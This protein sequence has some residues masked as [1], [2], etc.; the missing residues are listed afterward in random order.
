MSLRFMSD[1]IIIEDD[2]FHLFGSC[3]SLL[4][5]TLFFENILVIFDKTPGLSRTSNLKYAEK[6]LFEIL[7]KFSF[8]L[9]FFGY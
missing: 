3:T 9:F 5:E 2:F 4:I 1:I 6:N 8:F 7:L